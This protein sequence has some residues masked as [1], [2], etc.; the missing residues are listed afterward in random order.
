M[1]LVAA[2]MLATATGAV[3]APVALQLACVEGDRVAAG[4]LRQRL[5]ERG[6]RSAGCRVHVR[7]VS[8][9]AMAKE[10]FRI[11]RQGDDII[12][13]AKAT[14]GLVYAAGWILRHAD[15]LQLKLD[16][17]VVEQPRQAVRGTQIGYRFK[18]NSYD[19][20]TIAM[21]RRRIEDF[22]LWGVNRIQII[23]P[24]SDDAPTSPLMPVPPEKAVTAMAQ[25]ATALGLDVAIF[26]PALDDYDGGAADAA[27]AGRL[28]ALLRSLPKVDALYIPGGDP[29]H[30]PPDRLFPLAQRLA[31][32]LR[33]RFPRAELLLSTQGFD[34]AGLDTFYAQLAKRPRWLSGI[35][36]GPQTRESVA[37]HL[38]R[39]G[40]QY[41]VELYPDTAHAMQA[42]LPVPDWHPA[43]A[44][45]QGR[46]TVNPR[47]AAM[48][49][50]FD[51]LSPGTSGAVT[52]SEGVNDDWNVHQWLAL[53]WK[54]DSEP[55]IATQYSRFY[56]GDP[57][58]AAIPAMLEANW[59]GDPADNVGIDATLDAVDR[60]KSTSWQ[61]DLYRYRAVYDALV[62]ARLTGARARQ[63][64]ALYALRQAPG[65]GPD[66]A[67]AGARFAYARMD[68]KRVAALYE[69]LV[70]LADQLRAKAGV[71]LSV[72]RH[73]AS[74]WRRG[75]NLDRAMI[76][77]NDRVAVERDMQAA[78]ALPNPAER[79]KALV[80]IGDRWGMADFALYDDLGD[81]GNEPHLVRG[82]GYPDDP[83]L[84]RSAIDGVAA[85]SPNEGWRMA[86]LSYAEALYEQP[87]TLHYEGLEKGRAYRLRYTWAGEDYV[88]PLTLTANGVP[89]PAPS[90]RSSNP[91]RVEL[92][93]PQVLTAGGTLDLGWTRPPGIGGGGRGRQIAE[94]WLIPQPLNQAAL[95][96]ATP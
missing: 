23:A 50:A 64:E 53:G 52:Y 33:A 69:R 25:A 60:I 38:R 36:V 28:D 72:E 87:L 67:V 68:M 48:R 57:A 35:F 95:A 44:L 4:L 80:A 2:L 3:P 58:F 13:R 34:A 74:H 76:D 14:R 45:T 79:T 22:A 86:E 70:V 19:A 90:T 8:S 20:W 65:V 63:A 30:T 88:L 89:L 6:A 62:R 78:L 12:I 59:R 75:A 27:E 29:G 47:P 81:P 91:Q 5:A 37:M 77:L 7:M 92:A 26:Y 11:E 66:A 10:S 84:W 18:N 73:G 24:R 94:V 71:Q 82:P 42:Q 51:H 55:N 96:G 49:A 16:A 54:A 15:G 83:Q 85:H 17:S 32:V 9:S 21:L 1:S 39:I 43:F 40:G 31:G 93:I 61:A 56:I 41:P 46:E